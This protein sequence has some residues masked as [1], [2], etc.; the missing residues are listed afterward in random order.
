MLTGNDMSTTWLF[1]ASNEHAEIIAHGG[2]I[3]RGSFTT[4]KPIVVCRKS[5]RS[6]SAVLNKSEY[7]AGI[8]QPQRD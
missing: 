7:A 1:Q 8:R 3:D 5:V 2:T 6:S 4:C